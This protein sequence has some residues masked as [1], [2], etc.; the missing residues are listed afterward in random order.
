LAD[1]AAN[2]ANL[3]AFMVMVLLNAEVRA[4]PIEHLND[5]SGPSFSVDLQIEM[6]SSI[7]NGGQSVLLNQHKGTPY[8]P[9][10]PRKAL[11]A[12]VRCRT[13]RSRARN[14]SALAWAASLF[15][16]TKRIVGLCAASQ[17]ASA[18]VV[19][20]FCR[21][22]SSVDTCSRLMAAVCCPHWVLRSYGEAWWSA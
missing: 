6:I 8:S 14:T 10:W 12:C 21:Y 9:R 15:T 20:F 16:D 7:C 5:L 22:S 2:A 13:R 1:T 3:A 19:S 17:I 18:S 4:E 11:I